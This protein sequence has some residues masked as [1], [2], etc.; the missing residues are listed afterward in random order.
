VRKGDN[1]TAICE[2]IV[3]TMLDPQLLTTLL[4]ST[5][6]YGNSFT[7]LYVDDI[8]TPQETRTNLEF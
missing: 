1:L 6:R 8:R 5:V 4:A 7:L 2:P 3:Y